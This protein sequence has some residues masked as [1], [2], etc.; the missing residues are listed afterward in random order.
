MKKISRL[1][2]AL[3]A[4]LML[5]TGFVGCHSKDEIAFTIGESKFTSAMFSCVQFF[6][7]QSARSAI[8]NHLTDNELSTENIK[9]EN[10]KFDEE[11]KVAATGTPYEKFVRQSAI[12]M[13]RQN[14]AIEAL[15]KAE[16]LE[17]DEDSRNSASW[18]AWAYW[19]FGCDYSTYA[20]YAQMGMESQLYSYY[21]PYAYILAEN[22]V[23][24]E[25]YLEYMLFDAKYSFYF[26]HLYGEGGAKE[27]KKDDLKKF[28]TEHY[29]LADNITFS[30]MDSD[31]KKLSDEKLKELKAI[32]DGYAERLNAGESFDVI[33]KE[34]T[35]RQ[36][37][38][39]KNTSSTTSTSSDK[40]SSTASG[41]ASSNTSSIVS[42]EA[43][44]SS[45]TSSTA[46]TTTSSSTTSSGSTK[47][48]PESF[49]GLYGDEET[50]SE[51]KMME[52]YKKQ[53]LN[54]AVVLEDTENSQYILFV[55]R[56]LLDEDYEDYW[57]DYL[58]LN[59]SYLLKQ[60]EYDDALDEKGNA[61]KLYEDTHATSPFDVDEITF[62]LDE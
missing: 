50:G 38:A 24:Y 22:G 26:E 7:A 56:D 49:K 37:E 43:A 44:S 27:I 21:A 52:Q 28:M 18:E 9:Y 8:Y 14:A 25:T 16:K 41:N 58:K 2:A 33:Y 34:E 5:V 54:K 13:L 6:S 10:Y 31:N 47:Y 20:Q 46:S 40:N 4:V 12:D 15:M 30:Q 55:K 23:A 17:L 60:D 42:S 32:A 11:G 53:E 51:N 62:T 29:V 3:L 36:E 57:Y 61:M 39:S 1:L 48:S 45:E 19:N 59:V 35:K